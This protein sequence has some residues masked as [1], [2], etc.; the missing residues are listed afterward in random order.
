MGVRAY[1]HTCRAVAMVFLF[2][3][4]MTFKQDL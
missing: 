2:D 1:E 3:V 4:Y